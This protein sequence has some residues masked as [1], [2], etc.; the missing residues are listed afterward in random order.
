MKRF[1]LLTGL[2][3]FCF[4]TA[5]SQSISPTCELN[6]KVDNV[7]RAADSLS[8]L[9][10]TMQTLLPYDTWSQFQQAVRNNVGLSAFDLCGSYRDQFRNIYVTVGKELGSQFDQLVRAI[11]PQRRMEEREVQRRMD[12]AF[13]CYF[14]SE[15]GNILPESILKMAGMYN[16]K[17]GP[18]KAAGPCERTAKSCMNDARRNY[19]SALRQCASAAAGL[20]GLLGGWVGGG[21]ALFCVMQASNDEMNDLIICI[22][23]YRDCI[24]SSQ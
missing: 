15:T 3:I 4:C 10:R 5:N 19:H 13:E 14:K 2:F 22:G 11:D 16:T 9:M 6:N 20:G 23:N 24:E 7:V 1:C 21:V 8:G 17:G 12:E 18:D